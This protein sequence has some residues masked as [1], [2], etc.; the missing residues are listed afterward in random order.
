[1]TEIRS[2]KE[3]YL[4]TT[5]IVTPK[6]LVINSIASGTTAKANDNR[7]Y[8]KKGTNRNVYCKKQAPAFDTISL[9]FPSTLHIPKD[10]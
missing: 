8:L 1:M 5:A 10:N 6:T 7:W 4:R 3:N 9:F 2:G